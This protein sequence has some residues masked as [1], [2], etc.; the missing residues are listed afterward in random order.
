[1]MYR[2]KIVLVRNAKETNQQELIK[3]MTGFAEATPSDSFA[4]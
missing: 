2:G 4:A 1:V 3:F